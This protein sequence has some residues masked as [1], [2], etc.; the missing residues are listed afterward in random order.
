MAAL[1]TPFSFVGEYAIT[2]TNLRRRWTK[3]HAGDREPWPTDAKVMAAWVL[4]H[5]GEFEKAAKAGLQAGSAGFTV[6][7][8]ATCMYANYLEPSEKSRRELFLQVAQRGY[9]MESGA[10]T[11]SGAA[12]ELLENA[13]VQHAYLGR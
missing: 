9:V 6:A 8:K 7:N 10:I 11:L 2:A 3:L 12:H 4:F 13:A 5:R 1:W